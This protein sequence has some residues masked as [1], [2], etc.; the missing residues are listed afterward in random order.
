MMSCVANL[1]PDQSPSVDQGEDRLRWGS[2]MKEAWDA[3]SLVHGLQSYVCLCQKYIFDELQSALGK[4][5]KKRRQEPQIAA[6]AAGPAEARR[7]SLVGLF[8]VEFSGSS[9]RDFGLR[10]SGKRWSASSW[11]KPGPPATRT[12][13]LLRHMG[14]RSSEVSDQ[15]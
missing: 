10:V 12:A 4:L 8:C 15:R 14:T 13:G 7:L 3:G 9:L 1:A 5:L 2:C 6:P 11:T